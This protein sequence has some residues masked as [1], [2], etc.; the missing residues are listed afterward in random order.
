MSSTSFDV[1]CAVWQSS[2]PSQFLDV[3]VQARID[4]PST[5]VP[6]E[7]GV[8]VEIVTSELDLC[9]FMFQIFDF[10]IY[11]MVIKP[12]KAHWLFFNIQDSTD[13]TLAADDDKEVL[14]D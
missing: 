3:Q 5:R 11:T 7:E 14:E 6:A 1:H 8:T 13:A 2:Q 9:I 10:V 4:V 12:N